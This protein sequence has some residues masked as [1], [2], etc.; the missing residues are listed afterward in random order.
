MR[1]RHD[2]A[3]MSALVR[4]LHAPPG[5]VVYIEQPRP[6]PLDGKQVREECMLQEGASGRLACFPK[7]VRNGWH[8]DAL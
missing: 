3:A 6:V 8:G 7:L 4:D 1:R 5:T 2:P